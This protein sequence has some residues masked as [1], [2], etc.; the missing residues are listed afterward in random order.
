MTSIAYRILK[1][2]SMIKKSILAN[3]IFFTVATFIRI[4]S[5]SYVNSIVTE[6]L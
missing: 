6:N 2:E 5:F 1:F 3:H 4:D